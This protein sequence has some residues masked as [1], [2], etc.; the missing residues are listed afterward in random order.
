[1]A[2]YFDLIMH[3]L[4]QQHGTIHTLAKRSGIDRSTIYQFRRGDRT[5]SR[6]QIFQICRAL[7]LSPADQ[8]SLLDLWEISSVGSRLFHQRRIMQQLIQNLPVWPE[9]VPPLHLSG[10]DQPPEAAAFSSAAAVDSAARQLLRHAAFHHFNLRLI[11]QPT[12]QALIEALISSY[13]S[14][15]GRVEHIICLDRN[16]ELSDS[17]YNLNCI[18]GLLRLG[19]QYSDYAPQYY[20]DCCEVRFNQMT[21]FPNLLLTEDCAMQISSDWQTALMLTH[22]KQIRQLHSVFEQMHK[23]TMPLAHQF[24]FTNVSEQYTFGDS[25]L[26]PPVPK[27]GCSVLSLKSDL[28]LVSIIPPDKL[29]RM[30]TPKL[31]PEAVNKI[32]CAL[33]QFQQQLDLATQHM[34][35]TQERLRWFMDTGL[36]T[37][38]P[39]RLYRPFPPAFRLDVLRRLSKHISDGQKILHLCTNPQLCPP[40]HW[41]IMFYPNDMLFLEYAGDNSLHYFCITEMSSTVAFSDYYDALLTHEDVLS[42]EQSAQYVRS[43]LAEYTERFAAD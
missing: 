4:T 27:P 17:F 13:P 15:T 16:S 32:F 6:T 30:L 26:V 33:T 40:E 41:C 1:M 31:Q 24:H 35:L 8:N 14:N 10:Q 11:A 36:T 25:T 3:H 21:P 20:Y 5:P 38:F 19:A 43:L 22:P 23:H 12:N 18:P 9:A 2:E 34:I 37:L 42:P 7:T 29:S 28:E 39:A